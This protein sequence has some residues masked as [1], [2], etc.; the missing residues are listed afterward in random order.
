[1]LSWLSFNYECDIGYLTSFTFFIFLTLSYVLFY[2]DVLLEFVFCIAV[3]S[4]LCV[5]WCITPRVLQVCCVAVGST[6]KKISPSE[7]NFPCHIILVELEFFIYGPD[8]KICIYISNGSFPQ[9]LW[10]TQLVEK[11]H[12][13]K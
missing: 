7:I 8:P 12:D 6:M 1:M 4:V 10:D 13:I 5:D 11:V 9:F 3:F 2:V